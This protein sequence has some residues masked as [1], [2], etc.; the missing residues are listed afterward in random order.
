MGSRQAMIAQAQAWLGRNEADGSFR[1]I[2][3]TY[4]SRTPRARGYALKYTDEWC[5]GFVSAVAIASGNS[6]VVPM[7]VSCY[8]MTQNAKAMGIWVENDAYVPSVGDIIMYDWNDSGA[9]DNVGTPDHV[10]L[11]E[12]AGGGYITV[13]EGNYNS[14]VQRRKI[15]VNARNIRGFIC[16]KYTNT[17][18]SA[19]AIGNTTIAKQVLAGIWGNGHERKQR[20]TA[21]GYD[22]N[23]VQAEVN[24]LVSGK[25]KPATKTTGQ[26]ADEVIKGKWGSGEE[27]KQK[28]TAA[29][30]DYGAVQ[31][32]VN[33][34]MTAKTVGQ[35]A[36]E[37]IK[38]MWGAGDVRKQKLTAAGYDY[39]AV[40]AEVNRRLS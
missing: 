28:L 31:A 15:A 35:L 14:A 22:Y 12:S 18:A 40:Q 2:I 10:G 21:A 38:G 1:G 11:V 3:D 39:N 27:R 17:P 33:K 29:G 24:K 37:V 8:Y 16:P 9:G 36:D 13:I 26:L 23:A 30:Y 5:A 20:L 34:R 19:P 32:E 7:E 25:S 4:N 6:D